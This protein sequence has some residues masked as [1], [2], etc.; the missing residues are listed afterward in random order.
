M[1]TG[2]E[3]ENYLIEEWVAM[4]ELVDLCEKPGIERLHHLPACLIRFHDVVN[5]RGVMSGNLGI[6]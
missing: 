2:R 5:Y 4:A 3:Q 1:R 6:I